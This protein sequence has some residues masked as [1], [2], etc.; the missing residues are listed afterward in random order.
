MSNITTNRQQPLLAMFLLSVLVYITK[1][2][3]YVNGTRTFSLIEDLIYWVFMM[4]FIITLYLS[5]GKIG[6]LEK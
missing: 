1:L 4:V 3:G 2:F 5:L 6:L